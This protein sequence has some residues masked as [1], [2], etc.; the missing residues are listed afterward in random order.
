MTE[1][2]QPRRVT[3]GLPKSLHDMV[4]AEARSQRRSLNSQL[5]WELERSL[6]SHT[7]PTPVPPRIKN[8]RDAAVEHAYWEEVRREESE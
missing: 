5:V 6:D 2:E 7:W 1:P 4:V 3:I 8:I